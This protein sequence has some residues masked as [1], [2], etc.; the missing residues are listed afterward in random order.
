MCFDF[1]CMSTGC[2]TIRFVFGFFVFLL[3]FQTQL[4]INRQQQQLKAD[5]KE[6]EIKK[7]MVRKMEQKEKLKEE[8]IKWMAMTLACASSE[9]GMDRKEDGDEEDEQVQVKTH[10]PRTQCKK[11]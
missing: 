11:E 10:C 4:I 6:N 1:G 8:E 5:D 2:T 9:L 3:H 7:L